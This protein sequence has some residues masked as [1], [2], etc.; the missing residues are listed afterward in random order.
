M[1]YIY[2]S[3]SLPDTSGLTVYER[4]KKK[5][6]TC[7]VQFNLGALKFCVYVLS[8]TD[9][10]SADYPYSARTTNCCFPLLPENTMGYGTTAPTRKL[11]QSVGCEKVKPVVLKLFDQSRALLFNDPRKHGK[12]LLKLNCLSVSIYQDVFFSTGEITKN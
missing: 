7:T 6:W 1:Y 4:R 9:S 8:G 10:Y 11:K 3:D 5:T 12:T 2:C